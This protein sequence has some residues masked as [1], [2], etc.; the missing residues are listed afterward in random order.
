MDRAEAIQRAW[1]IASFG[2][3][4]V[5]LT[6]LQI[7]TGKSFMGIS[8]VYPP[9]VTRKKHPRAFWMN[10]IVCGAIGLFAIGLALTRL[11]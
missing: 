9:W 10:V 11:I 6:L 3:V 8:P 5:I 4:F 7:R 2:A 1:F